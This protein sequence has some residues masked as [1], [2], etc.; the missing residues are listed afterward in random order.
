MFLPGGDGI[1]EPDRG[2][3]TSLFHGASCDRSA[4]QW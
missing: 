4:L 2:Y 1:R 3:L